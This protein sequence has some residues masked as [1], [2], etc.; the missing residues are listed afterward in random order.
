MARQRVGTPRFLIDF[1]TFARH[2]GLI[3]IDG[4]LFKLNPSHSKSIELSYDGYYRAYYQTTFH[5]SRWLNCLEYVFVL[6][7][8]LYS[9]ETQISIYTTYS[10]QHPDYDSSWSPQGEYIVRNTVNCTAEQA[11]FRFT[12]DKDGWAFAEHTKNL[13]PNMDRMVV[14]FESQTSPNTSIGD[15]STGWIYEMPHS[16]D[17]SLKLGYVNES[18]KTQTTKGG[19]TLTNTGWS[20]P[21]YWLDMPQ[22]FTKDDNTP[23]DSYKGLA[24]SARRTWDLSFSYLDDTDMLKRDYPGNT[25]LEHGVFYGRGITGQDFSVLGVSDTFFSKVVHCTANFKLPFIFQPNKDVNEFAICRIDG[26]SF[27]LNQ[28]AN[29]VYDVSMKIV[30]TW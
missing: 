25:R 21:P 23:I 3:N 19:H 30:E 1:P 12:L 11:S 15:V 24:P 17:L 16:P 26:N 8:K 27:T 9:D 2:H 5:E 7:S 18:I 13:H 20:E 6:G 14:R 22:W 10:G 28:V 29:N 4:E